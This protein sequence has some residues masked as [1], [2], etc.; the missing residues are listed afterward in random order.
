MLW[1]VLSAAVATA[2]FGIL[3]NIHGKNLTLA[4]V[5][6]GLG[7]FVFAI[8]V[9][10]DY[11][12]YI[13]MFFASV[14]MTIFAEVSARWR[15]APATM[16]LAAALIPIVPGGRLFNFVLHLL[17]GDNALAVVDG[18]NTLLEAGAIAVGIIVVSSITKVLVRRLNRRRTLLKSS[19]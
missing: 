2:A 11:E 8:S 3:F 14:A 15:K 10:N 17:E 13:G 6:G 5:N 1:E 9:A 19:G 16:F 4:G 18:I 7:Y 12:S